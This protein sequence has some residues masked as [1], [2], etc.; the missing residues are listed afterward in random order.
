MGSIAGHVTYDGDVPTPTIVVEG[1]STQQVLYVSDG[2][3]LR[4]AVAFIGDAA[5]E[6]DRRP[7][8][9]AVLNQRSF[10]F[11]P[12]VLAVRDTTPIRFTNDDPANH[13]VRSTDPN[14][15]NR[16]SFFTGTG[17][18]ERRT[19]RANDASRPIVVE[20]DIHPWMR[21]WIYA[22][23]HPYFAV[24][25]ADGRFRIEGV[26][27]G[28]HTLAVRQPAAGLRRDVPVEVLEGA[29]ADVHVAFTSADVSGIQQ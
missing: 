14:P 10:I 8:A 23:T 18:G 15:A 24:T 6:P 3:H 1:G 13:N 7:A 29:T 4:Y 16:F 17:G 25:T 12:Q 21:A 9:P 20:C 27:I 11:E 19:V 5:R 2:G 22:F 28:R 26:P